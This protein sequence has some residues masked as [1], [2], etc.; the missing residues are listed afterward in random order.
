MT[1]IAPC[2]G[3]GY[4]CMKVQ[5]ALGGVVLGF[6]GEC[7]GLFFKDGRFW[8]VLAKY[9]GARRELYIGDGC[10]S[11]LFNTQRDDCLK[12]EAEKYA[13]VKHKEGA[14]A[15]ECEQDKGLQR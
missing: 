6:Q 12:G 14:D 3:C 10:S 5:C 7:D 15:G 8:C 13:K 1:K 11:T 9:S 2:V 4:C